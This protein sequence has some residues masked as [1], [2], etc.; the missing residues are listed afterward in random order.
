M[1]GAGERGRTEFPRPLLSRGG[2]DGQTAQVPPLQN[3]G[4][5]GTGVDSPN[6]ISG[7]FNVS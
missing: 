7:P 5:E 1:R 6:L 3:N 2:A 4:R